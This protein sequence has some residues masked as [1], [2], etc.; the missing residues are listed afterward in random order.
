M[1]KDYCK[2]VCDGSYLICEIKDCKDNTVGLEDYTVE[3]VQLTEEEFEALPEFDG[4]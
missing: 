4:W 2:I 3:I 1:R